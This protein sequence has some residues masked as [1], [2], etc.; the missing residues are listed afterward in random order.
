MHLFL[1]M[2][3]ENMSCLSTEQTRRWAGQ[4]STILYL[5]AVLDSN[6]IKEER[7]YPKSPQG[8]SELSITQLHF[9][10][11]PPFFFFPFPL[12]PLFFL[13]PFLFLSALKHQSTLAFVLTYISSAA[14]N[15]SLKLSNLVLPQYVQLSYT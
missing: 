8:H 4:Y 10:L 12:S 2:L 9:S 14:P 11:H 13:C 6:S 3:P 1:S 7:P 15:A 5:L